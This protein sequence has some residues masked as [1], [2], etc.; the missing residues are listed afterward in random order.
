MDWSFM[1]ILEE[2]RRFAGT[3]QQ[4]HEQFIEMFDTDLLVVPANSPRFLRMQAPQVAGVVA[5]GIEGTTS[6]DGGSDLTKVADHT[7]S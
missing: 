7:T 3:R 6:A 1:S 4:Q 2:F 5:R